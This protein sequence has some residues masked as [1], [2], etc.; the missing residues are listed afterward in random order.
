MKTL[1]VHTNG[2]HK[3]GKRGSHVSTVSIY[4]Q[5]DPMGG[6]RLYYEQMRWLPILELL[7][8]ISI[9]S[10]IIIQA[11]ILTLVLGCVAG[12]SQPSP[13]SSSSSPSPSLS[14]LPLWSVLGYFCHQI[15]ETAACFFICLIHLFLWK[16]EISQ[17]HRF[18]FDSLVRSMQLIATIKF[19]LQCSH[20]ASALT[21]DQPPHK[22]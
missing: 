3:N 19:F 14:V 18:L 16:N 4:R 5:E 20:P 13:G 17:S 1:Q 15:V 21:S 11:M 10:L 9:H 12:S 22:V 7:E 8:H 6:E 2:G